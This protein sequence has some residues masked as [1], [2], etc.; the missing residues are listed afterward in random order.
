MSLDHGQEAEGADGDH[1]DAPQE[2]DAR[3]HPHRGAARPRG[4][5]RESAEGI[6]YP[7][8]SS[9]DRQ[10]V[11]KGKDEQDQAALEVPVVPIYIQEK[12]HPQALVENLRKTG[13][14]RRG[15]ARAHTVQRSRPM[16]STAI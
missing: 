13:E 9:L 12:V 1:V 16:G 4:R 5:G 10:L 14:G 11:W 7:R 2:R 3:Q 8:D 6:L 15:G